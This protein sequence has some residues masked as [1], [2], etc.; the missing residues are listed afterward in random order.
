[1]SLTR[2]SGYFMPGSKACARW[3][4]TTMSLVC[5]VGMV[6]SRPEALR[7]LPSTRSLMGSTYV[8]GQVQQPPR[9][10]RRVEAAAR[11]ALLEVQVAAVRR[12]VV[13]GEGDELAP[14]CDVTR[15][16]EPFPHV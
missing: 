7:K 12:P 6:C 11:R 2:A 9:V 1:M 13:R 16:H 10:R 8:G 14:A 15:R 4:S 5:F 3:S